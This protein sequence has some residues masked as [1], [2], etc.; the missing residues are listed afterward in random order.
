M[1][2]LRR[3]IAS[4]SV[5]AILSSLVVSTTAFAGLNYDDVPTNEWYAQYVDE[6]ATGGYL[7]TTGGKF[8]PGKD[9]TRADA[10]AWLVGLAGLE[11]EAGE[12]T[13]KDVPK[14]HPQFEAIE[15]AAAHG[16]VNGY[17]GDKA[18]YFGPNDQITR[19]QFSKMAV[20]AFDL[21]LVEDCDMFTD[22][23]KISD[24]ACEYVATAYAWSVIDGHPSGAFKPG[25]NINRAEGSKMVV[26][27]NE[28]VLREDVELPSDDTADDTADDTT[29]DT[30]DDTA[31]V[32]GDLTVGVSADS[33]AEAFAPMNGFEIPYTTFSFSA[34]DS[35]EDVKVT[36]I[37]VTR[38]GL[39]SASNFSTV[40]LYMGN[41]QLGGDKTF[42]TSTNTASFNLT[43]TPLVIPA[44]SVAEVMV[45]GD[46]SGS[47]TS[48]ISGAR[49]MLGIAAA[50]DVV[51]N[52][53][54]GGTYPMYGETMQLSNSL[55][56]TLSITHTDVSGSLDVGDTDEVLGRVRLSAGSQEDVLVSMLR[57]K[58][59]GSATGPDDLANLKLWDGGN[60]VA[61][62]PEWDGDFMLFDFSQDPMSIEKGD[63]VNLVLR[64]DIVG[65]ISSTVGFE[66]KETKDVVAYGE[67]LGFRV[68]VTE[69]AAFTPTARSIIGG[70]LNFSLASDN[71]PSQQVADGADNVEFMR[72]NAV[73]GGDTVRV[74]NFGLVLNP[75]TASANEL[76]NITI[77]EVKEDGTL[78]TP[79]AGPI[80]GSTTTAGTAQNLVFTEDWELAAQ[81][82]MTYAVIADVNTSVSAADTFRFDIDVSA[83]TAEYTSNN[84]SL[85]ST[86]I[87]PSADVQGS[88][89]TV[90]APT[91]TM[92]T[93]SS[94]QDQTIVK[95][96]K[97]VKMVAF[98]MGANTVS[99]LT[100]TSLKLTQTTS[101]TDDY[102]DVTNIRIYED[103]KG[104]L[105]KLTQ[106]KDLTSNASP[107]ATFSSLNYT[108]PA[109]DTVK[110]VVLADIPSSATSAHVF[111]LGI[112]ATTDVTAQ[113]DEGR[114]S[115]VT[116]S[117]TPNAAGTTADVQVT[118]AG[119]GTLTAAVDGDTPI[120]S[121]MSTDSDM[122]L[123]SVFQFTA[124]DEAFEVTKLELN[125]AGT[126]EVESLT[127]EYQNKAG[128]TVTKTQ[129]VNSSGVAS[130]SGQTFWVPKNKDADFKVYVNTASEAEGADSGATV[131][132]DFDFDT[133]F[134]AFGDGSNSRSTSVGSAN[135]TGNDHVIYGSDLLVKMSSDTPASSDV[136]A[137][138]GQEVVKVD[139]TADG[140]NTPSIMA[141][142]FTVSGT[143]TLST[144][145]A[146]GAATLV[147]KT[148]ETEATEAYVTA[149]SD[150]TQAATTTIGFAAASSVNGIPVGSTVL[151]VDDEATDV[152]YAR[153]VVSITA[154]GVL[155]FTPAIGS[156]NDAATDTLNY[157][158][159]QPGTGKL[160]LGAAAL[161]TA[162]L[163][164]A[165]T[166]VTVASTDGF[167]LADVVTVRGATSAG[168]VI[169]CTGT[170]SAIGSATA[171]TISAADCTSDGTVVFN[172]ETTASAVAYT[173]LI[174]EEITGTEY[175]I[176][177]GDLTGANPSTQ[178]SRT[179]QLRLNAG[180]DITWNDDAPDLADDL[181]NPDEN[182]S[183][184]IQQANLNKEKDGYSNFPL[185]GNAL[186]FKT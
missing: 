177:K 163:A 18:G 2:K 181:D 164:D 9:L 105:T 67:V 5:V 134:E 126:D 81:T 78:G 21:P 153:E 28:P 144:T 102:Q 10:A 96:A 77:Y 43:S 136:T 157:V 174:D 3:V 90:A 98:T 48:N 42:S 68:N 65:G 7:G 36:Q 15:A 111:A 186:E 69:S 11:N 148:G 115:T 50:T 154:A 55:V 165:G 118:V 129:P 176:V 178:G 35:E 52:A 29:D 131:D 76:T 1:Q 94:P 158:P 151:I 73:T 147:D 46:M 106:S 135:V 140:E 128:E 159:L 121:V 64:G 152:T 108:I 184:A 31:E 30:T 95:N 141:L 16:V 142:A 32:M 61:E 22:S 49:N 167:S 124:K 12:P 117:G 57:Y 83:I 53:S 34:E 169:Q 130:F 82:T 123:A 79:V 156:Y 13:F 71:P 149:T 109:G 39:G 116:I 171:L 19:E 161:L 182:T 17:S 23:S 8:N 63:D 155:T 84:D 180:T 122:I 168:V 173:G 150:G 74:E 170:I 92:A 80:D 172:Q 107:T 44:G 110:F 41:K 179:V 87:T 132:V 45:T 66:I 100:L 138:S 54:V 139:F 93:A 143:A 58:Q 40:R 97:D 119:T 101:G 26:K 99:D 160:Y 137:G 88:V 89:M 133:N 183:F 60:L 127:V 6:L 75:A 113:D 91:L 112:A 185:N 27:S 120:S 47:S 145:T 59:S 24:W 51:A 4:L 33:P 175:M 103:D 20:E 86:D 38:A 70:V 72:F 37:V 162:N 114:T 14:T 166:T 146:T 85:T 104:V 62:N 25:D 125:T 56:G